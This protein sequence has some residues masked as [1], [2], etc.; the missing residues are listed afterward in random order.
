MKEPN[1]GGVGGG[2]EE[3]GLPTASA[4][5]F[6]VL[7]TSPL[8]GKVPPPVARTASIKCTHGRVSTSWLASTAECVAGGADSETHGKRPCD[9]CKSKS[10]F[11]GFLGGGGGG[12]AGG[13]DVGPAGRG[14]SCAIV[15][16][17]FRR[18]QTEGVA[19]PQSLS[20]CFK[21]S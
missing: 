3:A 19:S 21:S 5:G 12:G 2:G 10:R 14:V 7:L 9:R 6:L 11:L 17:F 16:G 13:V 18:C 4:T 20:P 8:A 1:C 15:P